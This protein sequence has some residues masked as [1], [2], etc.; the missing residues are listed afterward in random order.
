MTAS[1]EMTVDQ[2]RHLQAIRGLRV[3]MDRCQNEIDG[4]ARAVIPDFHF[5]G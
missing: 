4:L 5:R 2:M 1:K 3:E